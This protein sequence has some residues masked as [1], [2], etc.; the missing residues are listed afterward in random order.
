M[1]VRDSES[2]ILSLVSEF[3]PRPPSATLP[4]VSQ[5]FENA[6]EPR[7]TAICKF[8]GGDAGEELWYDW[9][10][11][12]SIIETDIDVYSVYV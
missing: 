10:D 9:Y 7:A 2:T 11:G 1:I 6:S 8:V 3:I 4:P 5:L 12:I